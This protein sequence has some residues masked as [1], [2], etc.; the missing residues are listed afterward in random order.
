MKNLLQKSTLLLF[1]LITPLVANAKI[2]VYVDTYAAVGPCRY[3]ITGWIELNE[4]L[5]DQGY[6]SYAHAAIVRLRGTTSQDGC[7]P[8]ITISATYR[9]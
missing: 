1:L 4:V 3:H 8:T 7:A 5:H 2:K 9:S 6:N